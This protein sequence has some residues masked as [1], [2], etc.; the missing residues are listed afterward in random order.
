MLGDLPILGALFRSSAF[1]REE[2]ELLVVVKASLVRPL[3]EDEV[4]PL[5]GDDEL[6]EPTDFEFF[7]LGSTNPSKKSRS[8]KTSGTRTAPKA[9][10]GVRG[11]AGPIGFSRNY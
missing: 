3:D 10:S 9:D 6:N 1:Q 7:V 5:P 2:T 8:S 11:P 4:P